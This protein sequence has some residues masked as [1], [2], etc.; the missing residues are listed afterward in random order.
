MTN[1]K[2]EARR[3]RALDAILADIESAARQY[4]QRGMTPEQAV[5]AA[6]EANPQLYAEHKA[7]HRARCFRA[8]AGLTE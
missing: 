1:T 2:F 5:A 7:A 8:Q 3:L 4:K 6:L